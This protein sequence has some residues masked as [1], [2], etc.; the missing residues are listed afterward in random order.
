MNASTHFDRRGP[1]YDADETHRRIITILVSGAPLQ[2]DMRVLDIGT[3]TGTAALKAAEIVGSQGSVLGIDVSEGMLAEARRKGMAA[4]LQN[5]EFIHADAEQFD[6]PEES[7][8]FMF[9][10]SGRS[11]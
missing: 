11:S 9:C 6:L 7:L 2:P 1:T 8:D 4:G 3:G 10:A 5:V